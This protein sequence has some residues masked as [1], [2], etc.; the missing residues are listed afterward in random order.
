MKEIIAHT[1]SVK[2]SY[3]SNKC[4]S[5]MLYSIHYTL[6]KERAGLKELVEGTTKRGAGRMTGKSSRGNAHAREKRKK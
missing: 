3:K 6:K 5:V 1:V 2:R 4:K